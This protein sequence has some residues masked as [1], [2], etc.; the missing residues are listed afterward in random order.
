MQNN[1]R[2]YINE[3][4]ND[5]RIFSH[6]DVIAMDNEEGKYY[7]KAL[8]YQYGKIGFPRNSE[9]ASSDDVVFVQEYTRQDGTVVRAHYRSKAGRGNPDKPVMKSPKEYKS[10]LEKEI[11]DYMDRDVQERYG[12]GVNKTSIDYLQELMEML[13]E[14]ELEYVAPDIDDIEPNQA[15]LYPSNGMLTGQ[16][17]MSHDISNEIPA[18]NVQPYSKPSTQPKPASKPYTGREMN[19]SSI[20]LPERR[21]LG[22]LDDLAS[23]YSRNHKYRNIKATNKNL[24]REEINNKTKEIIDELTF[25][26]KD[27]STQEKILNILALYPEM[28]TSAV[29]YRLAK[30]RFTAEAVG[31][32]LDIP[33]SLSY[34][35]LSLNPK[36]FIEKDF[37]NDY[38]DMMSIENYSLK[39]HLSRMHKGI[40]DNTMVVKPRQVSP[41][42]R[43]VKASSCLQGF[44]VKNQS[45]IKSGKYKNKTLAG[46]SFY[47]E[48]DL[49]TLLGET[50][51]YNA[52][53]DRQGNLHL[54]IPD[55]YDF[56][57]REVL[58][59]NLS[60][61]EIKDK[62]INNNARIQQLL[63]LLTDYV[64]LLDITYTKDELS[65]IPG[66][67]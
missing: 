65:K 53:I 47:G 15:P 19:I 51:V 42:I 66:W 41:L 13:P 11:N 59:N 36:N 26:N 27:I 1:L 18:V 56:Y 16:I 63:G 58:L 52:Y 44:I 37:D 35:R 10:E 21:Y 57:M 46:I 23:E 49:G 48:K 34:Y 25:N 31:K 9:L 32:I 6:E 24:S 60:L 29:Q 2:D 64:L 55:Y 54:Q 30:N 12:A 7:Q 28:Y 39:E 43:K 50:H 5:N 33:L 62:T 14:T 40:N 67:K 38:T 61:K 17:E 3:V 4:M 45:A 8:D 22:I 20:E